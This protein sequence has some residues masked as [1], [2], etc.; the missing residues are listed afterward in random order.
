[1]GQRVYV[2]SIKSCTL[3]I[4]TNI[5]QV[6]KAVKEYGMCDQLVLCEIRMNEQ[7][8][9]NCGKDVTKLL[10]DVEVI[11]SKEKQCLVSDINNNTPKEIVNTYKEV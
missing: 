3:G 2:L 9:P 7:P 11:V 1:M 5:R 10:T 6:R 4:F 8:K